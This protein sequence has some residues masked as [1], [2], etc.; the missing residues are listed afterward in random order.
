MPESKKVFRQSALDRLSSPEQ[1]DTLMRVLGPAGWWALATTG[2][3]LL[4]ALLWSI[5][6]RI[7]VR[8]DGQG[9]LL[10]G[11]GIT[12]VTSGGA[13][14]LASLDVVLGDRVEAGQ[15]VARVALPDL[16]EQLDEA[17]RQ[18]A[19]ARAEVETGSRQAR[20]DAALD[21]RASGYELQA[22]EAKLE[23]LRAEVT[24]LENKEK[25]TQA[26]V[27]DGLVTADDL[28]QVRLDLG[29]ARS[30][31]VAGEADV[32]RLQTEQAKTLAAQ[33]SDREDR[34][35]RL[36]QAEQQVELLAER[37]R[38]EGEVRTAQEGRVVEIMAD[39]GS[40]LAPGTAVVG[41]EPPGSQGA[42]LQ[43]VAYLSALDAYEVE[44]GMEAQVVPS[45]VKKEQYGSLVA[46]VVTVADLPADQQGMM[47]VL[48]NEPLVTR[49]SSSGLPVE[50]RVDLVADSS[51]PS[52]YRWTSSSGPPIRIHDGTLCDVSVIVR[53]QAPIALAIPG[54]EK[55]LGL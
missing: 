31:V 22:A 19:A 13:G 40:E 44:A 41:I 15:V 26:L 7:P 37:L 34:T 24:R 20:R 10:R 6:G 49:L 3:L 36:L 39:V 29:Q 28:A 47:R 1:V 42:R 8:V 52:G 16:E 32:A 9:V 18:L 35:S 4:A 2:A 25:E 48:G 53:R 17:R 51:T 54:V 21:D 14:R 33:T 23:T 5:F 50:V 12:V 11:R 45:V 30:Q 38:V 43:L 27:A 55:A 46:R